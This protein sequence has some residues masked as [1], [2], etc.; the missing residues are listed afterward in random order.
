MVGSAITL[1]GEQFRR[2][3]MPLEPKDR[4]L[5]RL[6]TLPP[7]RG[8]GIGAYLLRSIALKET[9]R[10]GRVYVD[11]RVFNTPSIRTIERAGFSR[12]ATVKSLTREEAMGA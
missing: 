5:F 7:F 8:R 2:W 3:L 10:G 6:R 11:C 12:V 1:R 9:A 4:V